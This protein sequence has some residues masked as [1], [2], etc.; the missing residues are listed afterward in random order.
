VLDRGDRGSAHLD[1]GVAPWRY[2]P[3]RIAYPRAPHAQARI[4]HAQE[5]DVGK[6]DEGKVSLLPERM[7]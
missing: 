7:Y 2:I 4:K 6:K 5:G 1:S 3:L